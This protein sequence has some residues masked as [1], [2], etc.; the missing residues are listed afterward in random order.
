MALEHSFVI[1]DEA[2]NATMMQLKMF[3]TRMGAQS[4]FILTGDL[5]QVEL[6]GK[7]SSGLVRAIN[8]LR[9]IDGISVVEFNEQDIVRHK[10]VI[11]IVKAYAKSEDSEA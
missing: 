4:K 6:P 5:T 8:M 10:L 1:L 9:D 3:L 2:Q 11:D 7:P